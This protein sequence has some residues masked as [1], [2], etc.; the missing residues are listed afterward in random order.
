[1]LSDLERERLSLQCIQLPGQFGDWLI[2]LEDSISQLIRRRADDY[3][4]TKWVGGEM[5][6]ENKAMSRLFTFTILCLLS[7]KNMR[8]RSPVTHIHG[9]S[10]TTSNSLKDLL[11][12]PNEKKKLTSGCYS[13]LTDVG[14]KLPIVFTYHRANLIPHCHYH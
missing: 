10:R 1:M 9:S 12:S 2:L 11:Q 3:G 6:K 7:I 14:V 8:K 13:W 5:N 4:E